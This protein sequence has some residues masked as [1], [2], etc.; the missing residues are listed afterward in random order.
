MSGRI[1]NKQYLEGITSGGR[2]AVIKSH[3]DLMG[4]WPRDRVGNWKN[5]L[6]PS[7]TNQRKEA[8]KLTLN[9]LMYSVCGTYKSDPVHQPFIKRKLGR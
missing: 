6:I 2:V 4:I 7:R 3:N 8:I 5:E 1:L 9:I